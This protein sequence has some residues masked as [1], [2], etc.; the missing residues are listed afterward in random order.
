LN[1]PEP[2]RLSI[3]EAA[4]YLGVRPETVRTWIMRRAI[5]YYK[6]GKRV[7]ILRSD[8]D[9]ILDAARIEAEQPLAVG[10]TLLRR[11]RDAY[12]RRLLP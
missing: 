9:R 1:T 8:L 4:D 3:Q 7:L 2:A 5:P 11:A 10:A 12:A 6:I